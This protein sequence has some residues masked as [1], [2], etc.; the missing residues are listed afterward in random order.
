VAC[1][2][3]KGERTPKQCGCSAAAAVAREK[4]CVRTAKGRQSTSMQ[5]GG[6]A[7]C[8]IFNYFYYFD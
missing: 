8:F 5:C 4:H 2:T 3:S 7:I 1:A 6:G